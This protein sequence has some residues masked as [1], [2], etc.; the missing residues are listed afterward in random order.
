MAVQGVESAFV[1]PYMCASLLMISPWACRIGGRARDTYR[2]KK[3][4]KKK[5]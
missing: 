2:M 4:K 3:K 1:V 5:K